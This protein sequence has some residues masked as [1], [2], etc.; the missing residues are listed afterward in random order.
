MDTHKLSYLGTVIEEFLHY[1]R[2]CSVA[3]LARA[4]VLHFGCARFSMYNKEQLQVFEEDTY[5]QEWAN[6]SATK[7]R[8][9]R[10][11]NAFLKCHSRRNANKII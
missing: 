9:R 10:I 11:R 7:S 8:R 2:L 6:L 1:L 3:V 4:S 5:L